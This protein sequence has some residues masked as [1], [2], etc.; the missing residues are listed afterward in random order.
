VARISAAGA[1][2]DVQHLPSHGSAQEIACPAI[3][4][5]WMATRQGWLLHLSNG[6]RPAPAND[7]AFSSLIT[8]RPPDSG[9]PQVPP[10]APPPDTSGLV[11]EPPSLG[12][13]LTESPPVQERVR[14]ALLS[15][16]RSRVRRGDVL[17]LRFHLAVKARVR[18][19]AL[20]GRKA[21][22]HTARRTFPAGNRKLL[23][24]LTPKR[25][26]TKLSLQTHALA[27]LPTTSATGG[28]E[29]GA[30]PTTIGTSLAFPRLPAFRGPLG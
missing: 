8:Y 4:D 11:E 15:H 13:P 29:G 1:L 26:P 17:E 18:L 14:V 3:H 19:V 10:D 25:W 7:P 9:I 12:A 2:S 27:P 16:M 30:G 23:L 6:E 5:C 24:R 22:A 28:A 20:R 21:V